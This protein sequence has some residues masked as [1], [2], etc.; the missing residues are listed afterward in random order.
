[1]LTTPTYHTV[2]TAYLAL[3]RLASETPEHFIS[4]RGNAAR[5]VI[6]VS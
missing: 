1:M 4:A 3:L 6:G 2:E 5:E